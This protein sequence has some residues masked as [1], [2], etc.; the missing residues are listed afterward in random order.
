MPS[1]KSAAVL[2]T[3]NR[4][5]KWSITKWNRIQSVIRHIDDLEES[6]KKIHTDI[7]KERKTPTPNPKGGNQRGV[8]DYFFRHPCEG[9]GL[10]VKH[11]HQLSRF[12][13]AQE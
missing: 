1:P 5:R 7:R 6:F 11:E 10:D 9:R 4:E 12:L 13:P 2:S 8:Q 3:V